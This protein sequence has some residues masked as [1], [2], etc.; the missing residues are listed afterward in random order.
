MCK[1]EVE[2]TG[3]KSGLMKIKGNLTAKVRIIV[4]EGI[5]DGGTDK[6]KEKLEKASEATRIP[7]MMIQGRIVPHDLPMDAPRMSGTKAKI[8]PKALELQMFPNKTVLIDTGQVRSRSSVL[9]RVSQGKTTGPIEVAVRNEIIAIKPE[10]IKIEST[11]RPKVKAKN[12]ISGKRK[13]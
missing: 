6:I 7:G 2:A 13:P 12:R 9:S 8:L 4:L 10:I 11:S 5:S 3:T 1:Y